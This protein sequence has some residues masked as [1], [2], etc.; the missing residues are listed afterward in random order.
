M[1]RKASKIKRKKKK[2]KAVKK[3]TKSAWKQKIKKLKPAPRLKTA[4]NPSAKGMVFNSQQ[5]TRDKESSPQPLSKK[6]KDSIGKFIALGK[7]QGY[8]TYEQINNLLP[9]E[10]TESEK[11]EGVIAALNE[12]AIEITSTPIH[13]ERNGSKTEAGK[14]EKAKDESR[15]AGDEYEKGRMDDPV[16]LYLRQMG[17]IPLL[18][19]SQEIELAKRIEAAENDL[20]KAVYEM[21]T[22]RGEVL[23]L[24]NQ[25]LNGEVSLESIIEEDEEDKLMVTKRQL[26]GLTRRLRASRKGSH[27]VSLLMQFNLHIAIVEQ[28]IRIIKRKLR[29]LERNR[30]L[31]SRTKTQ[32]VRGQKSR[33]LE[34]NRAILRDLA[35]PE[36]KVHEQMKLVQRRERELA[37][38]K[39][40]L[41]AANLRLVVSIAKKYTNRGLSFLDLIQEGNIGLMKAVDKFEYKRGYKFSTYATW[42]IRQAITRSIAD[43]ARTIRIPVH[44]IETINKF[45]RASRHLVQE[46][47][48]E[49]TPEEVARVM[50]MPLDK[51]KGI[52]KIA[53]EPISLQTPIGDEGDT[54]FGDFIE[55][56]SAISP[57]NAT[58]YSMLKEQMD[59]VLETLTERE[60]KVLRL[61]F[62]I[63]DGYPRTLEEVGQIFNVTR[64][65]VR[66][67][68]AKALRKLRHPTRSRKLKNFLDI[69][70]SD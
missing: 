10:I 51:V 58:A 20:K 46:T 42:W 25:I 7:K 40:L 43:Q 68:E 50:K 61:R 27:N 35:Q 60:E 41:T 54:Q 28:I 55:D 59:D 56:K 22:V 62:G 11:I 9:P 70:L 14:K 39:K 47:G 16:R 63:G 15:E 1:K 64:E 48:R 24:V 34:E 53:Q 3:R 2:L 6:E 12:S 33:F 52:L 30:Q 26:K 31:L 57:A 65:R 13:Q 19:R 44:M 23:N 17:Q 69:K 8:L 36:K 18:T 29:I 37:K 21:P 49:P 45:F 5:D 38:A 66:Q 4:G 32:K 67:I